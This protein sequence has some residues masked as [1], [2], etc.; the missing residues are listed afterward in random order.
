MSSAERISHKQSLAP[1]EAGSAIAAIF[2]GAVATVGGSMLSGM[3][4]GAIYASSLARSGSSAQ[5]IVIAS[6]RLEPTSWVFIV[7]T[8]FVFAFS[9][10]GGYLCGRLSKRSHFRNAFILAA[11]I[12]LLE[13]LATN[14]RY[15]LELRVALCIGQIV[16]VVM[17]AAIARAQSIKHARP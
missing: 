6:Y 7:S 13:L 9:I 12:A 1:H 4:C 15:S 14:G 11:I 2:L 10:V 8:A 3:I 5:D 17:G 16:F